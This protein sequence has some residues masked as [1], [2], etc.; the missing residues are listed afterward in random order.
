MRYQNTR[1]RAT[2]EILE[3]T[4]DNHHADTLSIGEL[5]H[6]LQERGF[7]LLMAVLVLPNCV[8][9]PLPPGASTIF[10]IPLLFLAIQMLIGCPTPWLPAWLKEKTFKRA[11][12]A[13][14]IG[15]VSPRLKFVERVLKPRLLFLNSRIGE[16]M[17]GLFWL[18]CAISIAIPMPMTNFVPGVGILLISLGLL[19]RDGLVILLG[20]AV[21]TL[22]CLFTV[23]LLALGFKAIQSLLAPIVTIDIPDNFQ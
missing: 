21:G 18:M 1:P 14:I 15:K 10:S 11:T 8:P 22:G 23:A 12:L 6:T 13:A 20:M 16:R 3:E 7:G 4:V 17:V 19:N 2:S 5:T 9:I